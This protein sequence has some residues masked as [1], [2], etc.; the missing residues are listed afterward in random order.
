[1]TKMNLND[2]MNVAMQLINEIAAELNQQV[3]F[4]DAK[5]AGSI[6]AIASDLE[7]I[8]N[9]EFDKFINDAKEMMHHS[10]NIVFEDACHYAA[11][12]KDDSDNILEI[13]KDFA[14]SLYDKDKY[15]VENHRIVEK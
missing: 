14:N 10:I 9:A 4:N 2:K 6:L 3:D 1:M 11:N 15:F 8:E 12:Y 7:L 13:A 5:S